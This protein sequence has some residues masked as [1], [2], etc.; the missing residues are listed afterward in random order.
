MKTFSRFIILQKKHNISIREV[1]NYLLDAL[2]LSFACADESMAKSNKASL[3]RQ[4]KK[5]V[6]IETEML[7][8]CISIFDGMVLLQKD[9]KHYSTFGEI[10]DYLLMKILSTTQKI[11]FFITDRYLKS[12]ARK[13]RNIPGS[14][15]YEV[16][17][18]ERKMPSQ[19][20]KFLR[21]L[22][23]KMSLVKGSIENAGYPNGLPNWDTYLGTPRKQVYQDY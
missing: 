14:I 13:E 21:N 4:L 10:S 15:R 16:K 22:G 18:R 5:I 20:E 6:P 7:L 17:R 11:A 23:N 12:S 9:L 1:I 3:G 2:P 8:D 19:Y